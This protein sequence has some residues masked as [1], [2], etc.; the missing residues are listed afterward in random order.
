MT[1]GRVGCLLL[2]WPFLELFVLLWAA[3][4]WGW[5]PV[6]VA[7]LLSFMLGLIVIRI[8]VSA[9]GRSWSQAL[10]TLQQRQVIIDPETGNVLA[11]ESGAESPSTPAMT[12]P[13]QTMLL[14]PAGFALAVPGFLSDAVGAAMLL[15]I[16]RRRIAA[17]WAAGLGPRRDDRF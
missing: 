10:R 14:I 6:V 2:L 8:G 9:T 16:V 1:I 13:A 11:I 12:P 4:T 3:S 7:V 15:P 17:R 5:Q